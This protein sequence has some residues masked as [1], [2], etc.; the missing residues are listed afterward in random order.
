MYMYEVYNNI[1]IIILQKVIFQHMNDQIK[2]QRVVMVTYS[3]QLQFLDTT[4]LTAPSLTLTFVG[5]FKCN[6]Y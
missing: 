6:N 3:T 5:D 4:A 1:N 2:D